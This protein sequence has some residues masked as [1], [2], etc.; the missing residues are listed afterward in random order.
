MKNFEKQLIDCIPKLKG[1]IYKI[2]RDEQLVD[3][4]LQDTLLS[5]WRFRE[6]FNGDSKLITWLCKIAI[7]HI[8]LHWKKDKSDRHVDGFDLD[9]M[10]SNFGPFYTVLCGDMI[11]AC[12]TSRRL[13]GS[14]KAIVFRRMLGVSVQDISTEIGMGEGAIKSAYRRAKEKLRREPVFGYN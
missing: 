9:S 11:E 6:T 2:S 4:V 14:D 5:A 13:S 3:D 12:A 10:G 8:R 7:N 1:F